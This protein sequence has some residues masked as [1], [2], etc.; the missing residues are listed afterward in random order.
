MLHSHFVT[1]I[2]VY[3]STGIIIWKF[4]LFAQNISTTI[5]TTI[6]YNACYHIVNEI[7]S[8]ATCFHCF[9]QF[10][11]KKSTNKTKQNMKNILVVKWLFLP[12]FYYIF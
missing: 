12:P 6:I 7:K 1:N 2:Y 8:L 3:T 9:W 10:H 4:D 11:R 5:I